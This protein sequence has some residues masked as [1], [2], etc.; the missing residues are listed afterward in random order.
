MTLFGLLHQ[1]FM[2]KNTT[3][4]FCQAPK[5]HSFLHSSGMERFI[6]LD[7]DWQRWTK[8]GCWFITACD[9]IE[10]KWSYFRTFLHEG[11][12]VCSKIKQL[13]F[14]VV[15]TQ[16]EWLGLQ[17]DLFA[18]IM[19]WALPL[20]NPHGISQLQPSVLGVRYAWKKQTT[21]LSFITAA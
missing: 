5:E 3:K 4:C 2:Y 6:W 17:R 14:L 11:G 9:A 7:Y 19:P 10:W 1:Y 12:R 18:C 15:C 21:L 13:C 20:L 8:T 16:A